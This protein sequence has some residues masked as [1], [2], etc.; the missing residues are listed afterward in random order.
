MSIEREFLQS[1]A[2]ARERALDVSQSFI[3]QAPAGSG[4]T[5]LL[6]QRYLALLPTV[7]HPEQVLAITFTRKAAAEMQYRVI[8]ALRRA[9]D[10]QPAEST[11]EALT[12]SLAVRVLQHDIAQCWDLIASP[13]RLRIETIDAFAAGIARSAPISSALGGA[14]TTA[15][16]A[17]IPALYR[18]AA[19]ATLDHLGAEDDS[20]TAVETVLRHLDNNSRLYIDYLSDMLASRQQWL[21]ITGSGKLSAGVAT[22]VRAQLEQNVANVIERH[23]QAL[24]GLVPDFCRSELPPLLAAAAE[25]L[26]EQGADSHPLVNHPAPDRWPAA[27]ATARPHWQMIRDCLLTKEG[28]WRKTV[29]KNDGFPPRPKERKTGLLALLNALRDCEEMRSAL[30][31]ISSLPPPRY[32]DEQWQVLL[33]LFE[34]LPLAVVALRQLFSSRG[35]SDHVEVAIAADRALGTIDQ[36]GDVAL[37]L[38]YRLKHLLVDEMQD[39]S[40]AQYELLRKVTSGWTGSDGRTIFCVGDPMQSIYRFRDAEVGEFLLARNNGIGGVPLTPL[41]LRRNFRSGERLVNWF[42]KVFAEIFPGREDAAVGAIAYASSVPVDE[43]AGTGTCLVHALFDCQAGE[44]AAHT[45]Q[46]IHA[47]LADSD[48]ENIAV[49]VRSRTQLSELLPLLRRSAIEYQ[50]VEIERLTDLPEIADLLA[51]CRALSHDGDRLAWLALLRAP[52]VGMTWTDLLALARNDRHRPVVELLADDERLN[53]LSIDGRTRAERF[54]QTI[55]RYRAADG[56]ASLRDRCER[57]WYALGGPMLLPDTAALD[58]VNRFLAM[59]DSLDAAG[60]LQDVADIEARLDDERISSTVSAACRLQIMTMHKAKGLQFDH[61]ILPGLGRKTRGNQKSVL[62]WLTLPG[63]DGVSDMLISP[64][65]PRAEMEQDLLHQYIEQTEALKA[66]LE[67]DR[68]LYVAA[69]RARL[70]LHLIGAV[71]ST[72]DGDGIRPPGSQSLLHRLWPAIGLEFENAWRLRAGDASQPLP[73]ATES[74]ADSYLANPVLRRFSTPFTPPV[75][76]PPPER[77]SRTDTVA[78]T[79]EQEVEFSWVGSAARHAGTLVHR[80]LHRLAEQ[81]Q[82]PAPAALG[83]MRS[84]TASWARAAGVMAADVDEV[85]ERTERALA[86]ILDDEK[87][88]WVLLGDGAAELALT[89]E[90]EGRLVSVLIDRLRIDENGT[91]WIIDYKTSTHEGGDLES[92]LQQEA[93]RYGPQLEKYAHLYRN[94]CGETVRTALYFP[95]LREFVALDG[96]PSD[97]PPTERCG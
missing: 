81:N 96:P 31:R 21:G 89:G 57:A 49:L 17:E 54:L 1:D 58:N 63:E 12:Q 47:C 8:G 11:H 79:P 70:S 22:A 76:A 41:L 75:F 9:R 53:A 25:S 15:S 34:L 88:R 40:I 24:D 87:G 39:T 73:T 3:V 91:H 74:D 86:G 64:V 72:A 66:R 7:D 20:A 95:L 62:S 60:S 56:T 46:V 6:I 92:F 14:V 28:T 43:K 55:G 26:V 52:W 36:P 29:N 32:S 83:T 16:D 59:L 71:A 35:I 97:M 38:D 77:S 44:E 93:I 80:W 37:M 19:A 4:K 85:C 33:A 5:E 10:Q 27:I 48:E 68:L 18:Q 78:A 50:A 23:L 69:T 30:H 65:G 45:M 61:V 94:F 2:D 90:Y 82:A 84:T 51:L 13:N 42:N 67:L